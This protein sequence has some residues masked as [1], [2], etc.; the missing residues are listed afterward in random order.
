[1]N[2][3]EFIDKLEADGGWELN[4]CGYIRRTDTG[5]CP[6]E[7]VCNGASGTWFE[8][9]RELGF[10]PDQ[11][12]DLLQAADNCKSALRARLLKACGLEEA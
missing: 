6:A 11:R 1:M 5:C 2:I 7:H 9:L 10:T 4:H 12:F 8:C 3:T